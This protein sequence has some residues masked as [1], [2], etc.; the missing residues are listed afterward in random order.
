MAAKKL[1]INAD[2]YG[3]TEG[4]NR[5]IEESIEDG[6]VTSISV[7]SNFDTIYPLKGLIERHPRISVSCHLNPVVGPPIADPKDIP[8][9]LNDEGEFYHHDFQ[10]HM[11]SKHIRLDELEHELDLQIERTKELVPTVTHLD[12]HQN[13]HLFPRFF[14]L[15]IK[16]CKKHNVMRMRTHAHCICMEFKWRRLATIAYYATQ[17]KR[18]LTHGFARYEMAKARREGV[19]MCDRMLSIGYMS[20]SNKAMLDVWLQIIRNVP[21]GTN[22]IYCH[23]GYPDDRLRKYAAVIVDRRL[24]EL[25]VMKSPVLREEIDRCNVELISFHDI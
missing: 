4:I 25:D 23:P 14:A 8:T 5:A 11:D 24:Q 20:N 9:L 21:T 18:I 1:I 22:E 3:F 10:K 19:R 17:P 7:N 12:S 15:F 6:V 2:G 13:R 16:L